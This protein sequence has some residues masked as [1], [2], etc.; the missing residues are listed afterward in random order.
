[1]TLIQSS[2]VFRIYVNPWTDDDG[3]VEPEWTVP[4]LPDCSWQG[5]YGDCSFVGRGQS[6][7]SP[8]L[9]TRSESAA[10]KL[11]E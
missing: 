11:N 10:G 8:Q 9:C 6:K 4:L 5:G 3:Y 1:V 7:A 2:R